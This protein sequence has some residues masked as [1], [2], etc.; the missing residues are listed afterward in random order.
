MK[1]SSGY[2]HLLLFSS[3]YYHLFLFEEWRSSIR[4][5]DKCELLTSKPHNSRCTG[6][7][8]KGVYNDKANCKCLDTLT[9]HCLEPSPWPESSPVSQRHRAGTI[10]GTP[11]RS[12]GV[13]QGWLPCW[14]GALSQDEVGQEDD[15]WEI[16]EHCWGFD[17]CWAQRLV[18]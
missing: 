8:W 18:D 1:T 17:C 16:T 2:Y 14:T 13:P 7:S 4:K 6:R 9:Q 10:T 11:A 5:H 3:S 15:R 12:P